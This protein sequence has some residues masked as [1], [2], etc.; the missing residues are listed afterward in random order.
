L[1]N[2]IILT[3]VLKINYQTG[4]LLNMTGRLEMV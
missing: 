1:Y 4:I 2:H 3:Q